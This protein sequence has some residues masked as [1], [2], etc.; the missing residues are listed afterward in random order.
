[1]YPCKRESTASAIL[2]CTV[3]DFNA[4]KIVIDF[5]P[6]AVQHGCVVIVFL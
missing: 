2:N 1:M 5:I 6:L 3:F 4:C